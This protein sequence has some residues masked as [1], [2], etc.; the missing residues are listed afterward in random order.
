MTRS[1][2]P[3][4]E[5]PRPPAAVARW[6]WCRFDDLT[7]VELYA[8]LSLR[9]RVFVVEQACV[10]QDVDGRDHA[11]WHLLGWAPPG[12]PAGGAEQGEA[13]AAERGLLA[14]ARVFAPGVRHAAASVGRVIAAPEARGTGLGRALMAEA[15]RRA[16]DA[17][18]GVEVR[19]EA[20]QRLEAFYESF[21]F[22]R[23]G[24]APYDEDGILHVK[25]RR[26]P[27]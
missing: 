10:F 1:S 3:A 21:G 23:T 19:L 27:R 18:G 5:A 15:L 24:E 17:W 6:Q 4:A 11:A 14:Y 26:P 8:A 7:P 9:Q 13:R 22:A 16:E 2:S 12:A 25:M 20:Q